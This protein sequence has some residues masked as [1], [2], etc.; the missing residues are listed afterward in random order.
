MKLPKNCE[1]ISSPDVEN[2][3]L[4]H[5]AAGTVGVPHGH[6]G[7]RPVL[8]VQRKLDGTVEPEAIRPFLAGHLAKWCVPGRVHAI[9]GLPLGAT[10][11]VDKRRLRSRKAR[12]H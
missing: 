2:A 5:P 4:L 3:A 6:W 8:F 1:W 10:G 9:A 11:N 12:E 7:D